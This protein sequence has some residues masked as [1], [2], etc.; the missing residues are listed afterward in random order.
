MGLTMP[1]LD[2]VIAIQRDIYT[3]VA[4]RIGTF[5]ETGDWGLLAAYLPMG[6]VFGAVHAMTPGHS[7]LVL[8]TYLAGSSGSVL[9]GLLVSA[10]LAL[11]H[12]TM[13][14]VIALISLPLVSVAMG[15]AGRAQLLEDV[16]RGLLGLIGA[17]MLWQ[18][19]RGPHGHETGQNPAFGFFAG[20][21]PC[22]LTLFVMT[23]A[24]TRGV[25]EAGLG[26]AAAMM[27]GILSTLAIV[28]IASVVFRYSLIRS[29][30]RRPHLL[31]AT[32]QTI[33][34]I[35][36]AVLV[37]FALNEIFLPR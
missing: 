19:C 12:V 28:A 10:A 34:G 9:K 4:D 13:S 8:A 29:L 35:A 3:S 6:I 33:Q 23:L 25:P 21:I 18:A 17:W 22:P 2:L 16:S 27:I 1:F 14:V 15:S 7:K 5:A 30:A 26:F 11:T 32:T 24:I 31:A 37:G 20:L 36:G